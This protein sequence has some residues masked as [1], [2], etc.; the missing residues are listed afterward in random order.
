MLSR[1]FSAGNPAPEYSFSNLRKKH[2]FYV[3]F[4]SAAP[5]VCS[6]IHGHREDSSLKKKIP[7]FKL[8]FVY[9]LI[10]IFRILTFFAFWGHVID[11]T[12]LGSEITL[13]T[14]MDVLVIWGSSW[15][16]NR[17]WIWLICCI[18]KKNVCYLLFSHCLFSMT[19]QLSNLKINIIFYYFF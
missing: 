11:C 6:P 14:W 18:F 10:H 5:Y 12:F 17:I 9:W 15:R 2:A 4:F 16:E 8:K 1:T 13:Y 7:K 3:D 19:W